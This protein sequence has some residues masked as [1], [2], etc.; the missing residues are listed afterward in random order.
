MSELQKVVNWLQSIGL[1]IKPWSELNSSKNIPSFLE[2][3]KIFEGKIYINQKTHPGD[4]LHDAG[5]V[6]TTPSF[7]RSYLSGNLDIND[8]TFDELF[9]SKLID[10]SNSES[11]EWTAFMN[12]GETA[13]IAWSFAATIEIGELNRALIFENW[14]LTNEEKEALYS[15]LELSCSSRQSFYLG[16]NSLLHGKM[17]NKYENFPKLKR[18]IQI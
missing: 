13:A 17:L 6:A 7:L 2:N 14:S 8:N 10:Y 15:G 12:C 3:I 11:D 16:V 5:H 4:L 9:K 1:K 18:W